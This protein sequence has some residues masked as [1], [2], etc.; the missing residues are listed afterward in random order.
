MCVVTSLTHTYAYLDMF[1]VYTTFSSCPRT[2]VDNNTLSFSLSRSL[3]LSLSRSLFLFLSFSLSFS[4]SLS[5]SLSL[6]FSL[7]LSL[8]LF[9]ALSLSLSLGR[10]S[11]LFLIYVNH[12]RAC[13]NV[14]C[15]MYVDIYL[16][17]CV[18]FE[19]TRLFPRVLEFCLLFGN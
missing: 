8:S 1:Q 19:C 13:M 14:Y 7:V 3:S 9:L 18:C 5:L 4:L 11:D 2:L 6:S 16:H 17:G 10:A 15:S 12:L